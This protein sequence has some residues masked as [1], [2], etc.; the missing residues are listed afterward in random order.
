MLLELAPQIDIAQFCPANPPVTVKVTLVVVVA[1]CVIV[2][3]SPYILFG[4]GAPFAPVP[5]CHVVA[6]VPIIEIKYFAY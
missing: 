2:S 5:I 1:V 4:S 6:A 3:A